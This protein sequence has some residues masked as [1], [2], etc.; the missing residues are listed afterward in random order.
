MK[1]SQII[2]SILAV[3]CTGLQAMH[4]KPAAPSRKP[5][6]RPASAQRIARPAARQRP[7]AAAAAAARAAQNAAEQDLARALQMSFDEEKARQ[8]AASAAAASYDQQLDE[9]Y[10]FALHLS[11]NEEQQPSKIPQAA[12]QPVRRQAPAAQPVRR[13]TPAAQ[14][15]KRP[16]ADAR[17]PASH[18]RVAYNELPIPRSLQALHGA[19][20]RHIIVTRQGPNQCGS[21]SVANALAVQDLIRAGQPI[22]SVN[23]RARAA[24]YDH[25]LISHVI[26]T[27]TVERLANR[28][29]LVNAHTMARAPRALLG[30]GANTEFMIASTAHPEYN[31]LDR[32]V[33][34][35]R[36]QPT[37]A[38]HIL[39]NTGGHWVAISI[40]KQEGQMP[41]ILYMDSGNG[42]LKDNSVATGFIRYL[43]A[44]CIE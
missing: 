26:E 42:P 7:Q 35:F 12:A 36:T 40:I 19:A 21:R 43:Y 44:T 37:T 33:A 4:R 29:G 9:D 24:H 31:S 2:F 23:I 32:L 25:I 34:T 38:A 13:S 22:N 8:Q 28:N 17:V 18:V 3:L 15:A 30:R 10:A 20:V 41:Q 39:C 1:F 16:A 27:A 11:L 14:P 5:S 6:A